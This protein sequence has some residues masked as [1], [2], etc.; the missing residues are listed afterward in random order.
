MPDDGPLSRGTERDVHP[1]VTNA[2]VLA[3]GVPPILVL[4]AIGVAAVGIGYRT[5][6]YGTLPDLSGALSFANSE[7][8]VL[9]VGAAVGYM[10]LVWFNTVFG[11]GNVDA[12]IDQAEDIKDTAENIDDD[13]TEAE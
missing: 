3:L 13:T 11:T 8:A 7:L 4:W 10:Y 5:A 1:W 12:A 2:I 6:R 9:A